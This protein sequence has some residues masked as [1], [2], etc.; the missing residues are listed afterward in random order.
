[1][2]LFHQIAVP[3]QDG[4]RTDEEPQP[5]QDPAG[6]RRQECGEKGPVFRGESHSGV[7][8]ESPFKDADLVT[9]GENLD[10][11]VPI[12]QRQQPQRREGVR[13]G[14]IGQ[15]KE[16]GQTSCRTRSPP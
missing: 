15:A 9:Q 7:G 16:H 11:L 12:S 10:I 14:E 5:A 13:D 1:M 8:A 3:A 6:Q 2:T 4:F